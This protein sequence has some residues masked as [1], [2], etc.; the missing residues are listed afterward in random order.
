MAI[1]NLSDTKL[2]GILELGGFPL[3][4]IAIMNPATT[5]LSYG[6]ISVLFDKNT[7]DPANKANEVYGSD[8]YSPRFPQ[9]IQKV[10]KKELSKLE[11]YL[12]KNLYLEDTTYSGKYALTG[13]VI[14][15]SPLSIS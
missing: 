3:P 7:I 8:V 5:D 12:G 10:N 9:T 2:K 4:S 11:S 1:H 14:S 13:S 6:D 15:I